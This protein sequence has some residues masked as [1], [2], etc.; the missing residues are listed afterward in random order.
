[1]WRELNSKEILEKW[2]KA[3]EEFSK[4]RSPNYGKYAR[5]TCDAWYYC[6]LNNPSEPSSQWPNLNYR[7]NVTRIELQAQ[8]DMAMEVLSAKP[9]DG[10]D[11]LDRWLLSCGRFNGGLLGL[12]SH[13]LQHC[14]RESLLEAERRI[15]LGDAIVEGRERQIR[16]VRARLGGP[17]MWGPL[18]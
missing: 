16:R 4:S 5:V 3:A 10:R 14:G 6:A 12:T 13:L 7:A 2:I 11:L 1:M 9:H 18:T 8:L 17:R 15:A